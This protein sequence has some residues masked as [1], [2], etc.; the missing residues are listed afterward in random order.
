MP[1]K[2]VI[3][4][5]EGK[6]SGFI[7]KSNYSK[8]EYYSFLGVPYG[9]STVGPARFKDPVK[10]KPWNGILDCT[11]EKEGC[12][13]F[14]LRKRN[15]SGDED[16][17]YNNIHTPRIHV[18]GDPLKAVVFNIHPGG[19]S[20]GSPDPWCYGSPEFVMNRDIVYVCVGYRLHILGHLNLGLKECSGNQSVKDIILSLKWIKDNIHNFGG[21]PQNIT[22]LGSSSGSALVHS[23]LLSPV[24]KGL[25]HK[26]ILMGMYAFNP[27]L[28]TIDEN[29]TAAYELAKQIGYK[30]TADDKKK[31]LSYYKRLSLRN[32]L[33]ARPHAFFNQSTLPI[34]PTS[35][36][37]PMSDSGENS[38]TPL[39]P[40]K[41]IPSTNRVPI[42][43]GFCE[44]EAAMAFVRQLK[45][46]LSKNFRTAI[47]QNAWGWGA[48][49]NDDE[50]K[51]IYTQVESFYTDNHPIETAS[52]SIKCDVLTDIA[53]SDV[54]DSL[55]NIIAADLPDSVFVYKFQFEGNAGT[56]KDRI[57]QMMDEPL[58]GT[59]H[60]SDFSYWNHMTDHWDGK[61][62]VLTPKTRE[63]VELMTNLISSFAKTGNPNYETLPVNWKPSTKD[64]PCY[65]NINETLEVKDELLNGERM[66]FWHDLKKQFKRDH[67]LS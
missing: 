13:Q 64:H 44:R 5:K 35:P 56:M 33:L 31:L 55:I 63:K 34:F 4:V 32:L 30:G 7:A 1:K 26:A 12:E 53:L 20:H 45:H 52:P 48:H 40:E 19:F 51:H 36:F 58:E 18:K 62:T 29:A 60:A 2:V 16:C 39:S 14:S 21:D 15:F 23:L 50:L 6:I 22:I 3:T 9:Q 49:L 66:E 27:L 11:I 24:A 37:I 25:Y 59:Y 42:M 57:Y 54:Y 41:L 65:L 43:I 28:V 10:V 17:L 46:N 67:F 38:V 61:I 8:T 47:R